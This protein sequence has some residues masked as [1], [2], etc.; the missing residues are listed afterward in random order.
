MVLSHVLLIEDKTASIFS[1]SFNF[2]NIFGTRLVDN[3]NQIGRFFSF[4]FVSIHRCPE[5]Q[6]IMSFLILYVIVLYIRLHHHLFSHLCFCRS[7]C[8]LVNWHILKD[9]C[10]SL[11]MFW[12]GRW[13]R[14]SIRWPWIGTRQNLM[15]LILY[16]DEI[17]WCVFWVLEVLWHVCVDVVVN[18]HLFFVNR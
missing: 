9:V 5:G 14:I 18:S 12:V 3:S 4:T 11:T 2:L 1:I 17:H 13:W 15:S 10:R 7:I 6:L 16:L 8:N